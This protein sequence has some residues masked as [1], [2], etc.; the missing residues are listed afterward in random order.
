MDGAQWDGPGGVLP[1][2]VLRAL[3]TALGAPAPGLAVLELMNGPMVAS[4]EKPDASGVA[5]IV[6]SR[7]PA[8]RT[9]LPR[10]QDSFTPQFSDA[11]WTHVPMDGSARLRVEVIDRDVTTDDPMG[12][13]ELNA[14][15]FRAA[16][17]AGHVHPVRVD[18]QTN[19]Q[20]LFASISVI[21]ETP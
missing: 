10:V 13:L 18:E 2:G 21:Q 7:G 6:T 5:E 15:D 9:E 1:S 20:V 17:Q 4:L 11:R 3:G 14:E 8:F 19:R 12:T 16:A